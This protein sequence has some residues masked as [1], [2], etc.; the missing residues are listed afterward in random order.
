MSKLVGTFNNQM[1]E[2]FVTSSGTLFRPESLQS[3][4]T[5]AYGSVLLVRPVSFTLAAWIA[6]GLALALAALLVFGEYTKRT[7]VMGLLV[8]DKGFIKVTPQLPGLIVARHVR[9]GDV[10]QAGQPLFTISME[11]MATGE[12]ASSRGATAE[13]LAQLKKRRQ[14]LQVEQGQQILLMGQQQNQIQSRIAGFDRELEQLRRE[15]ATQQQRL[16]SVQSQVNRLQSLADQKFMSDQAVQQKKDELLDQLSRFQSIERAMME[17][18]RERA[19]LVSESSQLKVRAQRE[20]EQLNRATSELDGATAST[21]VQRQVVVT[22]PQ[23]GTVT[24]IVGEVGQLAAGTPL[25]TILPDGAK[26]VATLFAQSAAVGFIQTQ[27]T[28]NLRFAA[29]PYQKFGQYKGK[30]VD[31]SR[32]ALS[33]SELPQALGQM[34]G[35]MGS[36]QGTNTGAAD[37]LYR[38]T[39]ALNEQSVTTYGHTTVLKAGM[40]LEADVLQESRTLLEWVFEP[41]YSIKGRM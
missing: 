16:Q 31:V 5:K 6:A 18:Q 30:V 4:E 9:E 37:G 34:A 20:Q 39:V 21:E 3:L 28:V 1:T 25:L 2:T 22:A 35:S 36:A 24:G 8:P 27:Q 26:L 13:I 19:T 7:R 14:S 33:P 17:R 38:I 23:N 32:V 15:L 10:V 29:Y 11:R 41:L 40:H 12:A